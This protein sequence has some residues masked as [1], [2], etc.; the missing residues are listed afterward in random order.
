MRSI[1]LVLIIAAFLPLGC[2]SVTASCNQDSQCDDGLFCN[3]KESCDTNSHKC[4]AGTAPSCDDSVA[5][6]I[7]ICDDDAGKCDHVAS[8]NMCGA[9]MTCDVM[10]GCVAACDAMACNTAC[11]G[12][13]SAS[14]ACVGAA[15][16]Q[17]TGAPG[18][19]TGSA[20]LLGH[21]ASDSA[22]NHAGITVSLSGTTLST[23]T[24]ADGTYTFKMVPAGVYTVTFSMTKYIPTTL[25]GVTVSPTFSTTAPTV[26][27]G[28]G[29]LM[30]QATLASF[31]TLPADFRYT[32]D[33]LHGVFNES[34]LFGG[35]GQLYSYA[36]DGSAGTTGLLN[37]SS[38]AP[39]TAGVLQVSN[40]HVV[41]AFNSSI[42]SR[43]LNASAA[44]FV[45]AAPPLP[46]ASG[47]ATVALM[48]TVG[49]YAL[50]QINDP[51]KGATPLSWIAAPTDGST[52]IPIWTQ[53]AGVSATLAFNDDS[54]IVYATS[55]GGSNVNMHTYNIRAKMDTPAALVASATAIAFD[56]VTSDHAYVL[57]HESVA[58]NSRA[59][60]YK[61]GAT[62]ATV[63]GGTV[64]VA[65]PQVMPDASGFIFY[66]GT[67][68]TGGWW[69]FGTS[70]TPTP[71]NPVL[72]DGIGNA[73]ATSGT[74]NLKI[75]GR[76]VGLTDSGGLKVVSIPT[77]A[78]S[79]PVAEVLDATAPT[80]LA[81]QPIG[82]PASPTSANIVWGSGANIQFKG[83]SITF[84]LTAAPTM[85]SLGSPQST[86]CTGSFSSTLSG[87][88]FYLCS[89]STTLNAFSPPFAAGVTPPK[90]V[91]SN[92]VANT[93]LGA[94]SQHAIYRKSDG[95]FYSNDAT[96]PA[97]LSKYGD[98]GTQFIVVNGWAFFYDN[99][100]G[101]TRVSLLTGSIIDEPLINCTVLPV[102]G[103]S[104]PDWNPVVA[105]TGMKYVSAG[106]TTCP[107]QENN[108]FS[109]SFSN[110]P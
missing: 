73:P 63:T 100:N 21:T 67:A 95:N 58:A 62:M 94:G 14:G 56:A 12:A 22:H 3:G 107:N 6:T 18:T 80:L 51:S 30:G 1:R 87:A 65:Q 60:V 86:T 13:G 10:G 66:D 41:Y 16:C 47:T 76:I 44:A 25:Q 19:L 37:T 7:D 70:V 101:L 32:P 42:W 72:L 84:P 36:V 82:D 61:V 69:F 79:T 74:G 109:V 97:L 90:A 57:G 45:L 50:V 27:L 68:T 83:T 102:F 54:N 81:Y 17:C 39:L 35:Q 40:D 104:T 93:L 8:S 106:I 75:A 34:G 48:G 38:F 85:G 77:N 55:D 20:L 52:S 43:P 31:F 4:K 46:T 2:N 99:A 15:F 71:G 49:A 23:T 64:A 33:R 105:G 89:D 24:A 28:H 110:L 5:C 88:F 108:P 59:F 9:G 11:T 78:N 53:T 98:P 103:A 29:Q 92:V 96:T 91:D 26:T